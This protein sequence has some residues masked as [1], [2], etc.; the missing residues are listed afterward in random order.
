MIQFYVVYLHFGYLEE[1]GVYSLY[2][3]LMNFGLKLVLFNGI[4]VEIDLKKDLKEHLNV[5]LELQ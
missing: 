2:M 4:L 1:F 5:V 3:H